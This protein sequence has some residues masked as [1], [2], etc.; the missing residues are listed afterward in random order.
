[1]LRVTP[2]LLLLGCFGSATPVDFGDPALLGPLEEVNLAPEVPA[3]GADAFPEDI[4]FVSGEDEDNDRY[5]AHARAWVHADSVDVWDALRQLEVYADRREVDEYALIEDNVLPDFDFSFLV[6]N[7]VDDVVNVNYEVTWVH[8]LQEGS[9]EVPEE[10]A[11]RW[12]KTDGTAFIDL[13]AGTVIVRRVDSGLC[14][15]EMIEHLR[16][17][18]RDEA[19]LV[20]FLDDLYGDVLATVHGT[21]LPTY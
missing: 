17:A 18:Q 11:I 16:A 3:D 4:V 6:S 2:C 15:L 13:L 5:Y 10:V 8:E 14:E 21:P 20:Q 1:M 7:H 9:V 19:T 12:E